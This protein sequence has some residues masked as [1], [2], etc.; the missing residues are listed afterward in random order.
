MSIA[1]GSR[2]PD[3]TLMLVTESG[4]QER[5]T[6]DLFGGRKVALFAVPGA[7]TPTCS[8]QHMPGFLAQADALKAAGADAIACVATNDAF[9]MGAWAKDQGVNGRVEIL[10]DGGGAFTRAIGMEF[11]TGGFG[12]KRSKRYSMLVDNGVVKL[13]NAEEGGGFEVSSA[14]HLLQQMSQ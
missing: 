7:F 9:V 14:E 11:D 6:S 10:A 4:P 5:S 2:L 3:A 8:A 12:G 1:V 13:L